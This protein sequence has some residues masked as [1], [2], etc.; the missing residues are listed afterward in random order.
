MVAGGVLGRVVAVVGTALFAEPDAHV[1]VS[2]GWRRQ[3]GGGPVLLDLVHEVDCLRWLVGEV[4]R[5]QATTSN[6]VHGFPV[7]DTA[8]EVLNRRRR[9][10]G[11]LLALRRGRLP[12]LVGA[13]LG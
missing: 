11:R 1:D 10:T 2:G 12:P 4:V 13:D 3:P 7:E 5:V 9:G 6:V 8:A